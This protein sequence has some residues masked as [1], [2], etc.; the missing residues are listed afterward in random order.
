MSGPRGVRTEF[1]DIFDTRGRAGAMTRLPE[2]AGWSVQSRAIAL[3]FTASRRPVPVV[4]QPRS[5]L[6]RRPA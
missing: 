6:R 2:T 5:R 1:A 3:G 4:G